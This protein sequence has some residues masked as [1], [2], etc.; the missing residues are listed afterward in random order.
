M[1]F[2][3][4]LIFQEKRKERKKY[5]RKNTK[6]KNRKGDQLMMIF[7]SHFSIFDQIILRSEFPHSFEN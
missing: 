1:T 7:E 5:E 4:A 6:V 2:H 3:L